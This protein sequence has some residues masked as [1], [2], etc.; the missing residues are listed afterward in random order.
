MSVTARFYLLA[1]PPSPA[2]PQ[3]ITAAAGTRRYAR[4]RLTASA[5]DATPTSARIHATR[6]RLRGSVRPPV[7]RAVPAHAPA[8][9]RSPHQ[10]DPPRERR[11][12]DVRRCSYSSE[13]GSLVS[14]PRTENGTE[15]R[16]SWSPD[17]VGS[18]AH[19]G[20]DNVPR[21]RCCVLPMVAACRTRRADGAERWC[22]FPAD[23][24]S[25]RGCS[26]ISEDSAESAGW[27]W[28][29]RVDADGVTLLCARTGIGSPT[30][31]LI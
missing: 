3:P 27:C 8:G 31:P 21:W 22:V 16:T 23:P 30:S 7:E 29:I 11:A 20:I 2:R 28:W 14:H 13:S 24:V 18:C 19:S 4:F 9:L 10:R 26:A 5:L 12:F 25:R 15:R 17:A 6:V 1:R